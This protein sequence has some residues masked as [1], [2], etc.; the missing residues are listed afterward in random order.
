MGWSWELTAIADE[1]RAVHE[2][3]AAFLVAPIVP[4][5]TPA[6]AEQT[7][8]PKKRARLRKEPDAGSDTAKAEDASDGTK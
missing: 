6:A 2:A 4:T 3:A 8:K 1:Q 5:E 7:E